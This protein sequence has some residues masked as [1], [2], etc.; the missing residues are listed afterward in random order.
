[1]SKTG[2][3]TQVPEAVKTSKCVFILKNNFKKFN[4]PM[5]HKSNVIVSYYKY[6][7]FQEILKICYEAYHTEAIIK[8]ISVEVVTI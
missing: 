4:F 3:G 8:V 6:L 7:C 5:S 2:N 1:M